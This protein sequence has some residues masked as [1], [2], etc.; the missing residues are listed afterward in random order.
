[1]NIPNDH[2]LLWVYEENDPDNCHVQ[3]F[4]IAQGIPQECKL[5]CAKNLVIDR[6]IQMAYIQAIR[7][8]QHFIYIENQYFLGSS[9]AYKHAGADNLIPMEIA[10]KIVSKIRAKENFRVYI[11]IPMWPEAR[12][13]QMMYE[14][15]AKEIKSANRVNAHP[16]DYLNFYCLGNREEYQKKSSSEASSLPNAECTGTRK[17]KSGRFMIYVHAKGMTVD[18]EYVIISSANINQRSMAGSRDTEIA[19]G[20]YQPHHTWAKKKYHPRG[21]VYGYRMS[22]WA[23]HL[24]KIHPCFKEASERECVDYVNTIAEDN[25]RRFTA[26]KF[27]SLQGH[28]LKYP[29]RIDGD[30]NISSR[31]GFETFPESRDAG[32]SKPL[33]FKA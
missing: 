12:T 18:D 4:R 14:L 32:K 24:A 19:M 13:M 30:G 22:L 26:E 11:V 27:M 17:A 5:V 16:T 15:I 29:V 7:S 9:Y 6:S 2:P 21:Q 8:A 25:W 31:P 20:A 10:L 3:I 33:S 28:I 23:E 1:M